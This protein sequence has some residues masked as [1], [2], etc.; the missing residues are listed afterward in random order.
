VDHILHQL[1]ML[2]LFGHIYQGQL[3]EVELLLNI[4]FICDA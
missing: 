3:D 4:L 2:K 1:D